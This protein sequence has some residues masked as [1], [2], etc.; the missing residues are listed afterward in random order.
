MKYGVGFEPRTLYVFDT[1][2]EALEKARAIREV[3]DK[4]TVVKI[5]I[6]DDQEEDK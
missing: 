6:L 2:E 4:D 1:E 5:L 3:V